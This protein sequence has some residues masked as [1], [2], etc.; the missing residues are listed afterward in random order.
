MSSNPSI[1]TEA[2]L[3][4]KIGEQDEIDQSAFDRP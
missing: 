3:D 2:I 4:A 1:A